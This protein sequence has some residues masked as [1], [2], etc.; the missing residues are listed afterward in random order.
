VS[1]PGA[2]S[3][4]LSRRVARPVA[5]DIAASRRFSAAIQISLTI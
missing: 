5:G 1:R 3:H 4:R 2:R